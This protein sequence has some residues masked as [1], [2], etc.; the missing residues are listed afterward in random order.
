MPSSMLRNAP[1]ERSAA[2]M[3]REQLNGNGSRNA[4]G[5]SIDAARK[6]ECFGKE[7]GAALGLFAPLFGAVQ[8]LRDKCK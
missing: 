1:R 8:A 6:P 3:A 5:E 7:A 4:L 2:E